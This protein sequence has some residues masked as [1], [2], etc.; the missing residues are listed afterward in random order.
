MIYLKA[1]VIYLNAKSWYVLLKLLGELYVLFNFMFVLF[2]CFVLRECNKREK[3]TQSNAEFPL[4][5]THEM[6]A[7]L[8]E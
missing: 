8:H 2:L 5:I 6:C 7:F 1:T 4:L 3:T